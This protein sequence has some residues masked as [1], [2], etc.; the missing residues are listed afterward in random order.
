MVVKVTQEFLDDTV[1]RLYDEHG[2]IDENIYDSFDSDYLFI[3]SLSHYDIYLI[4]TFQ[5]R[6]PFFV[7]IPGRGWCLAE[8]I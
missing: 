1:I 2:L 7:L 4:E 6:K 5:T 8:L 3:T